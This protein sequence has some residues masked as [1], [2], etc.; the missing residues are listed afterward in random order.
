QL[1]VSATV[2]NGVC[3]PTT[4]VGDVCGQGADNTLALCTGTQDCNITAGTTGTC[5]EAEAPPAP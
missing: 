3:S 5:A 2:T 1:G 4:E